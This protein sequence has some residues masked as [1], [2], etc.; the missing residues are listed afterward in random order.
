MANTE[1]RDELT[2][3]LIEYIYFS[4]ELKIPLPKDTTVETTPTSYFLHCRGQK[5]KIIIEPEN[6]F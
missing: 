5:L 4:G 2:R 6:F 1:K 3:Q